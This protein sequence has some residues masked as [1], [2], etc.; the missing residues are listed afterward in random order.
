MTEDR[1]STGGRQAS[2]DVSA[3]G[4]RAAGRALI[5]RIAELLDSMRDRKVTAGLTV[6]ENR[7]LIDASA[8][9]PE[10]GGD[11]EPLLAQTMG[12]YTW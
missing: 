9:M 5:D 7:Q 1:L 12:S 10:G 6:A 3:E 8:D 4:F 11:I 2:I